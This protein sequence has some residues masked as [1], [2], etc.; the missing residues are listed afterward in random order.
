MKRSKS[1]RRSRCRKVWRDVF[2]GAEKAAA[3]GRDVD[4]DGVRL[5]APATWE[6]KTPRVE[7]IRAEF[8]LRRAEGDGADGR[9]TV[10]VAGGSLKD[11]IEHGAPSSPASR[12]KNPRAI[13]G[14]RS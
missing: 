9:L 4:L 12:R 2:H 1:R 3:S 10:S 6:R 8:S 7:I 5:T 14:G 11:N 13:Q